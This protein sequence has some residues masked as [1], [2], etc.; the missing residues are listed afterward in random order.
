MY[1]KPLHAIQKITVSPSKQNLSVFCVYFPLLTHDMIKYCDDKRWS[2]IGCSEF[3]YRLIFHRGHSSILL[4]CHSFIVRATSKLSTITILFHFLF[5][6]HS[7]FFRRRDYLI[8]YITKFI[9]KTYTQIIKIRINIKYYQL[10]M[11][12]KE[13]KLSK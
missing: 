7:L 13:R 9:D 10:C 4:F 8:P 12:K 2:Y 11:S 6:F 3:I 5:H 1:L